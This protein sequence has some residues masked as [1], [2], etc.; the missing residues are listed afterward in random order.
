MAEPGPVH[1]GL[2]GS[3]R[4]FCAGGDVA[5]MAAADD[6]SGYLN[7][8]AGTMHLGILARSRLV[9]IAAGRLG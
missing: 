5:Q 8:L 2:Q 6:R 3:G 7:T 9:S 1:R 4:F